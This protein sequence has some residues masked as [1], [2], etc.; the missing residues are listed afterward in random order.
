[1]SAERPAIVLWIV[2]LLLAGCSPNGTLTGRISLESGPSPRGVAGASVFLIPAGEAFEREWQPT[3]DGYRDVLRPALERQR[4]AE[5]VAE[6]ARRTWD[7]AMATPGVSGVSLTQ[8][9][10][11]AAGRNWERQLW[12]QVQKTSVAAYEARQEALRVLSRQ[13]Q[14]AQTL[15]QRYAIRE[16]TSGEDGRYQITQLRRGKTY[17]F[18]RLKLADREVTWFRL[19]ELT[20]GKQQLDLT[21]RDAGGWPFAPGV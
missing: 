12:T 4:E 6:Q 14:R 21:E 2:L 1:M 15:L 18:A 20:G 10:R 3:V 17:V 19:V 7:R 8:W 16:V 13:S 9:N 11:S 5:R